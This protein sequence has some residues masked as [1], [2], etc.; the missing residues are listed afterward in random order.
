MGHLLPSGF[1]RLRLP[2]GLLPSGKFLA[3]RNSA[4]ESPE[5][6]RPAVSGPVEHP[7]FISPVAN[8]SAAPV[9][10]VAGLVLPRPLLWGGH[11][12]VF[13]RAS[14]DG[15][16]VCGGG[17]GAGVFFQRHDAQFLDV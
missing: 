9:V 10:L 17:S 3:W 2:A 5:R 16:P 4:L 14:L 1:R 15:E 11:G 7:G 6:L 12:D 13:S 8:L